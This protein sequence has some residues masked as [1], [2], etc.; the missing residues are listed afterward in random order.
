MRGEGPCGALMQ[1]ACM[2]I[3]DRQ[4]TDQHIEDV[5]L[6]IILQAAT[7]RLDSTGELFLRMCSIFN[8]ESQTILVAQEHYSSVMEALSE[9]SAAPEQIEDSIKGLEEE[10]DGAK[11]GPCCCEEIVQPTAKSACCEGASTYR[12]M[13][14]CCQEIVKHRS[15]K[16]DSSFIEVTELV[17]RLSKV[18]LSQ[19]MANI[20][21]R[22]RETVPNLVGTQKPA[23]QKWKLGR[24]LGSGAF[25]ECRLA[26]CQDTGMLFAVKSVPL[27]GSHKDIAG[28]LTSLQ[29]E[30]GVLRGMAHPH[31]VEVYGVSLDLGSGSIDAS[32]VQQMKEDEWNPCHARIDISMEFME[33]GSLAKLVEEFGPLSEGLAAFYAKQIIIGLEYLHVHG[34]IH[35]DIKPANCLLDKN[36]VLKL[37]DF[38]CAQI[39]GCDRVGG[40]FLEAQSGSGDVVDLIRNSSYGQHL[41]SKLESAGSHSGENGRVKHLEGTPSYMAPEVIRNKLYSPKADIWALG[42]T[43]LEIMTGVASYDASNPFTVMF[44]VGRGVQPKIPDTL[45]NEAKEFV[46]DCC[47]ATAVLRPTASQLLSN[48]FILHANQDAADKYRNTEKILN[49]AMLRLMA[50]ICGS[51]SVNHSRARLPPPRNMELI[52]P[53]EDIDNENTDLPMSV[54]TRVA[55]S[56]LLNQGQFVSVARCCF[57]QNHRK[58]SLCPNRSNAATATTLGTQKGL[59]KLPSHESPGFESPG[60]AQVTAM[61]QMILGPGLGKFTRP[62][63]TSA[64]GC[65]V[66]PAA[67]LRISHGPGKA[68]PGNDAR[69]P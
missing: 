47:R 7:N 57:E 16:R 31:V 21:K 25:G 42:L 40:R 43:V 65:H 1:L 13:S 58:L 39:V 30:I 46:T 45:G 60:G 44:L 54:T 61:I 29:R 33:G 36:G 67:N 51:E 56:S 62:P 28:T 53:A 50:S 59:D 68:K 15:K 38:G 17:Q 69:V 4:L 26:I 14:S 64:S 6:A 2:N 19:F 41:Y 63:E 49:V 11:N 10:F 34:I 9:C 20:R 55:L 66:V 12:T 32:E 24:V 35:G 8:L 22:V 48:P 18:C 37:S 52:A 5:A 27:K 23:P 3:S